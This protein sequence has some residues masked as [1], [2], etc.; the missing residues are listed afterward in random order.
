MSMYHTNNDPVARALR[1]LLGEHGPEALLMALVVELR[2]HRMFVS[3][4]PTVT[5]AC[6]LADEAL[7]QVLAQV[8]RFKQQAHRDEAL[9]RRGA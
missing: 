7:N 8:R 2:D 5:F 3:R 1:A 9:K 4:E 6:R